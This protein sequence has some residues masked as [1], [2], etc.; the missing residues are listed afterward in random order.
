MIIKYNSLLISITCEYKYLNK[1]TIVP[2]LG[3][4]VLEADIIYI[5]LDYFCK[6]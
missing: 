6:S 1:M 5:I 3:Y 4:A 2:I